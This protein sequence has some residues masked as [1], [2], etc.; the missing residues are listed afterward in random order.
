MDIF[1]IFAINALR[2]PIQKFVLAGE[3]KRG[4]ATWLA[5]ALDDRDR[6]AA[7]VPIVFNGL[8]MHIVIINIIE[9]L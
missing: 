7:I 8:N 1:E 2:I 5:G 3:S 6:V 4:W 9:L